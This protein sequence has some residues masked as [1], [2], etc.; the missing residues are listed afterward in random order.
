MT[1]ATRTVL[2]AALCV[3]V[4]VVWLATGGGDFWPRWV[5]FAAGVLLLG[6]FLLERALRVASVRHRWLALDAAAGGLLLAADL[7]VWALSGGGYFW[8][9]WTTLGV[10]L[11][12]GLHA[13]V[14]SRPPGARE[15]ELG[16]RV[17]ALTRSRRG[18]VDRQAAELKRVERDLH[19]GAQARLVSLALTLAM[20]GDLLQRD[21]ARRKAAAVADGGVVDGGV[22]D[23]GVV[24][25]GVV[26]GGVAD[27]GVA[28]GGV[29]DSAAA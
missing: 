16:E 11:I 4:T 15:R 17:A 28:D 5:Y 20:A 10:S 13:W 29:V 19:D 18:A 25:G 24:D 6:G 14:V 26:D 22:V 8:P 9:M 3:V 2:A 12:V 1:A 21:A 27:G 23:G 7:A